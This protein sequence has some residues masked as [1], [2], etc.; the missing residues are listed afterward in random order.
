MRAAELIELLDAASIANALVNTLD[1]LR[2]HPQ[3]RARE[4]W[5]E[6]AS[7]AGPIPALRPPPISDAYAAAMGGI[8]ALGEHTEGVLA[9]IG[10][11]KSEIAALRAGGLI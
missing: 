10:Y 3:L 7:P 9:W 2:E 6:V 11:S 5:S 1:G 4:R 8:P